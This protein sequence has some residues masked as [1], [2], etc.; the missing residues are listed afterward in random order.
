ML[1]EVITIDMHV[2]KLLQR[3]KCLVLMRDDETLGDFKFNLIGCDS[4][5]RNDAFEA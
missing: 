3:F 5:L 4:G 1:Y 2:A